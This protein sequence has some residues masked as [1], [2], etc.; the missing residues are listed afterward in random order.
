M[1][2]NF[3]ESSVAVNLVQKIKNCCGQTHPRWVMHYQALV[4]Q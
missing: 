3:S 2:A 4:I 1:S